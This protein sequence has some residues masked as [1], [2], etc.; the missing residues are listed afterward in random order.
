[1]SENPYGKPQTPSSAKTPRQM[2]PKR[3]LAYFFLGPVVMFIVRVIWTSCRVKIIGQEN[4]D[5]VLKEGKPVIPCYWHQQHI[6]CSWYMLNQI[7]K[8]MKVG[9]LISPSVDGEIPA[10]LV[11]ARGAHVIRGSSNRT[12]AQSLRDMYQIISKDGISPVTTS[13]GP[14]GPI[15]KFKQGAAMVA[16]ITKTSMLPL[17]YAAKNA[18]RLGSWDHFMI[19]YPFTT[20]VIAIGKP[21]MVPMGKASENLQL[22][23]DKMETAINGLM[24]T[25]AS[26][27]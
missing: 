5:R 9:F 13:D 18:R 21:V 12:G 8:G 10:R 20:V 14:T 26:Q 19:P 17:A 15:F 25:A 22:Y 7:K 16:R 6:F 2:T 1:M 27:L 3:K 24:E 23:Q 4:M 11:S